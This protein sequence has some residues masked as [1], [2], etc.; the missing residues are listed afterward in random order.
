MPLDIEIQGLFEIVW[1]Y[2]SIGSRLEGT[3]ELG[4][5]YFMP[6]TLNGIDLPNALI[7]ITPKKKIIETELTGRKGSVNEF[8]NIMN[9]DI[10]IRG[11]IVDRENPFPENGIMQLQE[12]WELNESITLQSALTD[13]F[14]QADDSVVIKSMNLPEMKGIENAQA[15]EI[16]LISDQDFD[17]ILT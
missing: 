10:K 17:L 13:I 12:M 11:I 9:Y 8:I 3:S 6:V 14:L 15:Y 7:S 1:P 2:T 4:Q 5:P 16:Q